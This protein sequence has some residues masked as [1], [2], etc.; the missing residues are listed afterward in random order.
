VGFLRV[1]K[2]LIKDFCGFFVSFLRFFVNFFRVLEGFLRIFAHNNGLRIALGAF[3]IN[4]T[5]N[6]LTETGE[7]TLQQRRKIKIAN[8][9]VKIMAKPPDNSIPEKQENL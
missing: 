4:R 5:H 1:L 7:A 9:M 8:M 2:R 3:Y 6:L